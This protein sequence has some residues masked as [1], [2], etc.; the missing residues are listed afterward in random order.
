M[1]ENDCIDSRLDTISPHTSFSPH[2]A[3]P[4]LPIDDTCHP[5]LP[6]FE[7]E[8]D[9]N[10]AEFTFFNPSLSNIPCR[11]PQ[12]KNLNENVHRTPSSKEKNEVE[13]ENSSS[14][15]KRGEYHS[16]QNEFLILNV[17]PGLQKSL[18]ATPSEPR[19]KISTKY[20]ESGTP[21]RASNRRTPFSPFTNKSLFSPLFSPPMSKRESSHQTSSQESD[22]SPQTSTREKEF[23]CST[24]DCT[25][26]ENKSSPSHIGDTEQFFKEVSAQ[27]NLDVTFFNPSL[28]GGGKRGLN[29]SANSSSSSFASP[30]RKKVKKDIVGVLTSVCSNCKEG[31][32]ARFYCLVCLDTLCKTCHEAHQRVKLTRDHKVA[33]MGKTPLYIGHN[34]GVGSTE[35]GHE[36]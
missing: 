11:N 7:T 24:V 33:T 26:S 25:F 13:K 14:S 9:A 20:L 21:S 34:D 27:E 6:I 18:Q 5:D 4:T 3:S 29:R 2:R 8:G 16:P 32:V 36:I 17:S 22:F 12:I 23:G 19:I 15:V 10:H 31:A 1:D 35:S 30:V 28:V